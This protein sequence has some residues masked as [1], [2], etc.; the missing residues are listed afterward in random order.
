[1]TIR[2]LLADD[3]DLVRTGLRMILDAQPGLQVVGEAPNGRE[4]VR[5]ARELRPD[6]CLFDVRMPVMDGIE[7]TRRLAG[8]DVADPLAVIAITTF[9]LDE[10]VYGALKA[11]ARGFLLKDAGPALLVQAIEAAA[12]GDALIAPAITA[13]LLE[14]FAGLEPSAAP[15][16]PLE[17]LTEREEEVLRT[18]A[19]G[20][21]NAEIAQRA[22]HQPE[23]RE[24]APREPD[25]KAR[26]PEPRRDR[27]LGLRDEAPHPG[28]LT[29]IVL[30]ADRESFLRPMCAGPSARMLRSMND[31]ASASHRPAA[32]RADWLIPAGL[33]ALALVPTV[34]GVVRLVGIAIGE[35]TLPDH[36]RMSAQ[37]LPVIVH[38]VSSLWFF[39]VG[40]F[41]FS[42]GL[43]RRKSAWHR[44]S[45]RVL[46]PLGIV[47]AATGL[48]MT[49]LFPPGKDDG[50]ILWGMRIVVGSAMIAFIAA[51]LLAVR[52]RDFGAHGRWMTRGYALGIGAGTQV[53]T[54]MPYTLVEGLQTPSGR[55]LFM[56]AGW[57]INVV[58]AEW[59][60]RRRRSIAVRPSFGHASRAAQPA[61]DAP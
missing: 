26:R 14:K 54:M 24:D 28:A 8:P 6:V 15:A 53:F 59:V 30:S 40:A 18:V 44:A 35:A 12:A 23:H 20:R 49:L 25:G 46:A 33:I 22:P 45:G 56:G 3:Q 11:G 38:I 37:P 51:G 1:M 2:V 43:R 10:Y 16:Q 4:A 58:I 50:S 34:A 41:Q 19:R 29:R 52:R 55:A 48:W 36:E 9:D 7:A 31:H 32:S 27:D 39:V 60:I 21:T 17:P 5:L 57:A 42:P 47:S 61:A 13:R